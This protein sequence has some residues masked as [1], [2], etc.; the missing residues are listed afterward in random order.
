MSTLTKH[1]KNLKNLLLHIIKLN[2]CFIKNYK[3]IHLFDRIFITYLI[4]Y[5]I[6][7]ETIHYSIGDLYFD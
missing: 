6:K 3:C 7:N 4:R 2:F 1:D 5:I